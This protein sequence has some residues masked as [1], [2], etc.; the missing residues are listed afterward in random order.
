VINKEKRQ[1]ASHGR[2]GW[3][4]IWFGGDPNHCHAMIIWRY[5]H[6]KSGLSEPGYRLTLIGDYE[7]DLRSD[8]A[9]TVLHIIVVF[10]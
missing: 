8:L 9:A 7:Y 10:I 5:D 3:L 2:G 4:I 1:S 6:Y